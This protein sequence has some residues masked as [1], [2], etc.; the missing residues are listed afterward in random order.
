VKLFS[1]LRNKT[2]WT[3]LLGVNITSCMM[4]A[5]AGSVDGVIIC[6]IA[7]ASCFAVLVTLDKEQD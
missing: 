2:F 5:F 4:S 3:V 6:G 1:A 7:M